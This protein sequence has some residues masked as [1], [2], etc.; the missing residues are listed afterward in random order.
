[1]VTQCGIAVNPN[2]PDLR[3]RLLRAG[4]PVTSI[5]KLKETAEEMCGKPKFIRGEGRVVAE[6]L[7]RDG[8]RMDE[9][10]MVRRS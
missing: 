1:M 5:E 10:H 9:I 4:L 6:V 7:Y 8:S 3:E 2:N